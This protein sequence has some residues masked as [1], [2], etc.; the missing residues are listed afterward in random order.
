MKKI[1]VIVAILA[2]L[3]YFWVLGSIGA[4]ECEQIS[5]GQCTVQSLFGIAGAWIGLK[6][7]DWGRDNVSNR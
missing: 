6:M 1:I 4:C 2:T 7:V 3:S 5:L